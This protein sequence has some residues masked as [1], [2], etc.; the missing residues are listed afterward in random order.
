MEAQLDTRIKPKATVSW[1]RDGRTI[2]SS[3]K[4][5]L[6]YE[7]SKGVLRLTIPNALLE[8][9][10]RVT[11]KAE[12]SY[13]VAE[14]SASIGVQKK[15]N[16]T[17]PQFLSELAPLTITEGDSLQTKV[18]ISGAPPPIAKWYVNGQLVC[19][20]EDTEIKNQEGVYSLVIHGCTT[21]MTGKIKCVAVN[22]MGE[23][24]IEGQ[25]KVVAP[26]PV[27]FE[28]TLTDATCRED[29]FDFNILK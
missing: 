24:Q 4:F 5:R 2:E 10:C 22:R 21:D 12:N 26:I 29:K 3:E 18:I 14:S 1:Q 7:E 25:L 11:I 17:K 8:D 6:E 19:Q 28:T 27:A 13:G 16:Q 23:A 15:V 20:T 9:K